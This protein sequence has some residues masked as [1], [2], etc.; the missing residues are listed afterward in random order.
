MWEVWSN[1]Q[2]HAKHLSL[3]LCKHVLRGLRECREVSEICMFTIPGIFMLK[4]TVI[5]VEAF[6]RSR[7]P[8]DNI[9]PVSILLTL[10]R[11][12]QLFIMSA[13]AGGCASAARVSSKYVVNFFS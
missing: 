10:V 5:G 11:K 9:I 13:S 8:E 6:L 4:V 2:R 3:K 1:V 12:K 7:G